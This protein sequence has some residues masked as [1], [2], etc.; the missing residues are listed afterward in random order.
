MSFKRRYV[1]IFHN[2]LK[3]LK[4]KKKKEKK[5]IGLENIFKLIVQ[6]IFQVFGIFGILEHQ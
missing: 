4:L 3:P 2:F 5:H 6:K 1:D